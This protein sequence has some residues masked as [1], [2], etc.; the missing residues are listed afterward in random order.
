[1]AGSAATPVGRVL[2]MTAEVMSIPGAKLEDLHMTSL[3]SC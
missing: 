3:A 1:M 2:L